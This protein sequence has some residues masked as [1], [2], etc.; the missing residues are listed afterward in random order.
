MQLYLPSLLP[1]WSSLH[2]LL[3]VHPNSLPPTPPTPDSLLPKLVQREYVNGR[4]RLLRVRSRG[5]DMPLQ[6]KA[7]FSQSTQDPVTW[8]SCAC[9]RVPSALLCSHC[10]FPDV[11]YSHTEEQELCLMV[12]AQA[13]KPFVPPLFT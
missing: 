3:S 1:A 4:A 13:G 6:L 9:L 7:K 5:L 12:A 2:H 11:I 8:L 10:A